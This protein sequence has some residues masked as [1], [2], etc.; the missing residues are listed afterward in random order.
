VFRHLLRQGRL[1]T[2][3]KNPLT[4]A[5]GTGASVPSSEQTGQPAGVVVTH[6]PHPEESVSEHE[7]VTLLGF[8]RRLASLRGYTLAGSFDPAARYQGHVY[9]VPGRTLGAEQARALGIR[10]P[11]DLFGGVV[12][13][14]FV[15][16]KAI[17][18]PLLAPGAAAPVG[19]Q[20]ELAPRLGDAVLAG[21]SAFDLADARQAGLQ[22]LARGPVRVKRVRASGG[23]GQAVVRDAAQLQTL[24]ATMD[25]DEVMTHGLVLE[26]NL[27][28]IRTFSVG[29]VRVGGLLASYFGVQRLTRNNEGHEVFGGSELSVVRGDFDRLFAERLAPEIRQAIEQAR[30]YDA[31]VHACFPGFYASRKNYDILLGRD[32]RGQWRSAVL[33]QSWRVGGATGPELAAL[34]AFHA[35]PR[36]ERVRAACY[37]VFGPSPEPPPNAIVYYRGR[38]PHLGLLTKYTV[39]EPDDHPR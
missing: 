2:L 39:V 30:R 35:D 27:D 33:E 31:A 8:A 12:P 24:L 6:L 21:L 9:F 22:L 32:A 29:Q 14:L 15:G 38:E 16:G 28:D 1:A 26:E 37:E 3:S 23:R 5:T 18:H 20:P 11:D 7:R 36:R 34:E 25:R 10:G 4:P 19:W 13:H 17:S